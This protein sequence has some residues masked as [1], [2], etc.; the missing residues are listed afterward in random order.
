M[1]VPM[2]ILASLRLHLVRKGGLGQA[3]FASPLV[4]VES[5]T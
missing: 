4:A 2:G 1:V 5:A 3:P